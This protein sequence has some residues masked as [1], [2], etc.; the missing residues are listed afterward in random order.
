MC[1]TQCSDRCIAYCDIP[2]HD[3]VGRSLLFVVA[4]WCVI[5][6][7]LLLNEHQSETLPKEF[8]GT[9]FNHLA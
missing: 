5:G 4:K 8:D 7:Q 2:N 6:L 9:I 1:L 3:V